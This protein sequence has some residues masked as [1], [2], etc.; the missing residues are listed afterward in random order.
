MIRNENSDENVD[1][2]KFMKKVL[3]S[4]IMKTFEVENDENDEE[5]LN[6]ENYDDIFV[7]SLCF[8]C[9]CTELG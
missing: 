1:L 3:M 4:K 9:N 8:E 5:K 7:Y 6:Y 2:M